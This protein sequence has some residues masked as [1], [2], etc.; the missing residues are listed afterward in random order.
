[1]RTA[2]RTES[3]PPVIGIAKRAVCG[4]TTDRDLE[5]GV[6]RPRSQPRPP[7]RV[8]YSSR[9]EPTAYGKQIGEPQAT[10]REQSATTSRS[11]VINLTQQHRLPTSG[12]RREPKRAG[13]VRIEKFTTAATRPRSRQPQAAANTSRSARR[14]YRPQGRHQWPLGAPDAGTSAPRPPLTCEDRDAPTAGAGAWSRT[15]EHLQ[16][17][18]GSR[19]AEK[20]SVKRR[21]R[22]GVG[23]PRAEEARSSPR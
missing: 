19:A 7:R 16:Y 5:G 22:S 4:G 1:V 18:T 10:R 14:W 3:A 21:R 12:R 20:P 13:G 2:A 8:A 11:T 17:G 9:D 15:E 23:R 6:R